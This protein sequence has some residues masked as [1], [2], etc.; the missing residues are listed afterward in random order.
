MYGNRCLDL[1][2][3]RYNFTLTSKGGRY[4]G[5]S[6]WHFTN[7]GLRQIENKYQSA[8]VLLRSFHIANSAPTWSPPAPNVAV[9][10][11]GAAMP[12]N[13]AGIIGP[14]DSKQLQQSTVLSIVSLHPRSDYF[15]GYGERHTGSAAV[16]GQLMAGDIAN[17][18]ITI[19]LTDPD[20]DQATLDA[21][22]TEVDPATKELYR[23]WVMEIEVQLL[24]NYNTDETG[25]PQ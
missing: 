10:L 12:N 13:T 19:R 5:S 2:R 7:P 14:S 22:W 16:C 9:N 4:E 25:L 1:A 11:S 6:T 8:S 17:S 23:T 3:S 24:L 18:D 21:V 20:G 15:A